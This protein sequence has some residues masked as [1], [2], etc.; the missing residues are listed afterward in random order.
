MRN[1]IK[2]NKEEL[3]KAIK[4]VC[5]NCSKL[6]YEEIEQWIL[7]DTSLYNWAK[8]EGVRI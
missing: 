6:T 7:N 8:K 5:T 4:N 2:K 3:K 1:F